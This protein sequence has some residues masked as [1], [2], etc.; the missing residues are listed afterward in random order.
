[1]GLRL[2]SVSREAQWLA[3]AQYPNQRWLSCLLPEHRF[4]PF[5]WVRGLFGARGWGPSVATGADPGARSRRDGRTYALLVCWCTITA[6]LEVGQPVSR[7]GGHRE[8]GLDTGE[9]TGS[10]CW[11]LEEPRGP[12]QLLERPLHACVCAWQGE[13]RGWCEQ[14]LDRAECLTLAAGGIYSH[15]YTRVGIFPV[16]GFHPSWPEW[17]RTRVC[18]RREHALSIPSVG[19]GDLELWQH[20]L[21]RANR[22]GS[23]AQPV[24]VENKEQQ[25]K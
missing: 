7:T 15:L 16:S 20:H 25:H 17:N 18:A 2:T 24:L 19:S 1:M 8:P 3:G 13:T 9:T 4:Q 21:R 10:A 14:W 23:S 6:G 12:S 5:S 11:L 22:V